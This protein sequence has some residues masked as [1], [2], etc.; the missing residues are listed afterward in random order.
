MVRSALQPSSPAQDWRDEGDGGEEGAQIFVQEGKALYFYFLGVTNGQVRRVRLKIEEHGG[1]VCAHRGDADVILCSAERVEALQKKYRYFPDLRV[2]DI[3]FVD[4]CIRRGRF[5]LTPYE[6]KSLPGRPPGQIQTDFTREDDVNLAKW[7]AQTIPFRENGGRQGNNIYKDLCDLADEPEY[8][9]VARHTWSSWQN[10][11]KKNMVRFDALIEVFVK[12]NPPRSDGRGQY[13]FTR[14]P[15]RHRQIRILESSDEEEEEDQVEHELV[16]NPVDARVRRQRESENGKERDVLASAKRARFEGSRVFNIETGRNGLQRSRD[17]GKGRVTQLEIEEEEDEDDALD[18]NG[19]DEPV[20]GLPVTPPS[21][22][23]QIPL[24]PPPRPNQ[25]P[26]NSQATLVGPV[27]S[28]LGGESSRARNPLVSEPHRSHG[29]QARKSAPHRLQTVAPPLTSAVPSSA[30]ARGNEA[31]ARPPVLQKD[32]GE[33]IPPTDGEDAAPAIA[34]NRPLPR[35]RQPGKK[36]PSAIAHDG[37]ARHTRS[38]SRSVEPVSMTAQRR[39]HNRRTRG[40]PARTAAA[41]NVDEIPPDSER[42]ADLPSLL[43]EDE[44]RERDDADNVDQ[45]LS[46]GVRSRTSMRETQEEDEVEGVLEVQSGA[47]SEASDRLSQLS[48]NNID[49]RL[50]RRY[51]RLESDDLQ[52]VQRLEQQEDITHLTI[53]EI[54]DNLDTLLM[55]VRIPSRQPS[56]I[57]RS[58]HRSPSS[59]SRATVLSEYVP[60]PDSRA[61]YVRKLQDFTDEHTPYKPL[62]GTRAE[63]HLSRTRRRR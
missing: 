10:R 39:P 62:P 17:K 20:G 29:S 22:T 13:P 35:P 14:Q 37:P 26:I 50:G 28:Q 48:G 4:V 8:T 40:G 7:L 51:R 3:T 59:S 12:E 56:S 25:E 30:A 31:T 24:S 45:R 36:V 23:Q 38:R 32:D 1:A 54:A 34:R 61:G 9:W 63:E 15:P 52:T 5:V 2:E 55:P 53:E 46:A 11:Y 33:V 18:W 58:V 49:S 42:R 19:Y 43:E 41:A 6:K 47:I 21:G 60:P 57:A 27:P 16:P 44:D